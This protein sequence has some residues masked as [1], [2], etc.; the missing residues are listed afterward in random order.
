MLYMLHIIH[1]CIMLKF[2]TIN[3]ENEIC[4]TNKECISGTDEKV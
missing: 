3:K 2:I 4:L 1:V